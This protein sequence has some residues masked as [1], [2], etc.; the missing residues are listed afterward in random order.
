MKKFVAGILAGA[1]IL[2]STIG[3]AGPV[4]TCEEKLRQMVSMIDI[5]RAGRDQAEMSLA[6]LFGKY[7]DAIKQIDELKTKESKPEAK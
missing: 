6:D 4:V 1:T 5:T 7:Q 3:F 2:S